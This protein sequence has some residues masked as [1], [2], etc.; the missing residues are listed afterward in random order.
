MSAIGRKPSVNNLYGLAANFRKLFRLD[1]QRCAHGSTLRQ[2]SRKQLKA[3]CSTRVLLSF[4]ID[5][6]EAGRRAMDGAES[7]A[8]H[9]CLFARP[10]GASSSKCHRHPQGGVFAKRL[11]AS[12][13]VFS[14][15]KARCRRY[16]SAKFPLVSNHDLRSEAR[17]LANNISISLLV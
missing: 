4:V 17:F 15:M 1:R 7:A 3:L 13:L 10:S 16:T 14:K 8:R 6:V 9:G 2:V 5:C 12:F 11:F